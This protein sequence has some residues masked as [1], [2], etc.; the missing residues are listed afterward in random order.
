MINAGDTVRVIRHP[1]AEGTF[2]MDA[3][4]AVAEHNSDLYYLEGREGHP[5]YEEEIEVVEE[6]LAD[7]EKELLYPDSTDLAKPNWEEIVEGSEVTIKYLP[8]NE[9]FTTTVHAGDYDNLEVLGWAFDQGEDPEFEDI[10]LLSVEQPKSE[11]PTEH[12]SIIDKG[13]E[14]EFVLATDNHWVR[15]SDGY[16][17][18]YNSSLGENFTVKRVGRKR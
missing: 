5:L 12:G 3:T 11:L 13:E 18:T 15:L 8:T 1:Y 17:V 2:D 7:W 9:T 14:G 6:P 16:R 4:Y 10:E